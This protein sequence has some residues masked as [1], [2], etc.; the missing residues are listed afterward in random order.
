MVKKWLHGDPAHNPQP[1]AYHRPG[2]KWQADSI[3]KGL[4]DFFLH[5]FS[6]QGARQKVQ[7]HAA[8]VAVLRAGAITLEHQVVSPFGDG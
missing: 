2:R 3:L 6:L 8:E 7:Q 4:P 1:N 5:P